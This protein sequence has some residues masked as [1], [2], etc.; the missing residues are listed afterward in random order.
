MR[1]KR[2]PDEIKTQVEQRIQTFNSQILRDP[3]VYYLPC[4]QGACVYL[5][6]SAYGQTSPI[7]RL[8]YTG[9]IDHWEFAIF[10][11]SDERYDPDEWLFPGSEHVDGTI[12]GAMHAGMAAY[13]P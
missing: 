12:E 6:R 13:P 5:D 1:G 4:Y 11:Y 9:T 2:I 8:R 3:N 10:K 7:C